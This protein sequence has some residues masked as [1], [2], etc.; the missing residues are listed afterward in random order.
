[1]KAVMVKSHR[2][3]TLYARVFVVISLLIAI[4]AI[5]II[6]LGNFYITQLTIR[7]QAIQT[8]FDAQSIA[9][10]QQNN[11][12]SMNASL[13]ARHYQIFASLSNVIKDPSLLAS[14][15]LINGD[16]LA[17]Q[18]NFEQTLESYIYNYELATSANMSTILN[19][20]LNDNPNIGP[21]I[22]NDQQRAL[23][24]VNGTNGLWAQYRN[25]QDQALTKLQAL[26]NH[27][28]ESITMLNNEYN[29][30]YLTLWQANKQFIDLRNTWQ[31][32]VDSAASMGKTVSKV[33]PSQTSPVYLTI[34]FT[35]IILL[36]YASVWGFTIFQFRRS[37]SLYGEGK[38]SGNT[39]IPPSGSIPPVPQLP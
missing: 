2:S 3:M 34:V 21:T 37:F 39:P 6:F 18:A 23:N 35:C 26:E 27:P 9:A 4:L 16:I 7:S 24:A 30:T 19:I 17:R 29:A 22:I 33:G 28:P 15:E 8:S 5:F 25:L 13:Q 11:L 31:I 10:Q 1:M 20:L 36:I 32:V 14:G 38:N 12:A